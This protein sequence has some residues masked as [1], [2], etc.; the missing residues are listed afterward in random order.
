MA[1]TDRYGLPIT[2]SSPLAA[3]HFGDGMDRLLSFGAGADESFAAAVQADE[4]LAVAHAGV[5]LLAVA[6]G[7]AATAR[8]AAERARRTVGAAT[9][10]EQRHVEALSA[11]IAGETARGLALV[12]EHVA[13]FPRDALLVNQTSSAIGFAGGSRREEQRLTFLERLAP[14]YGDDWWFQSAL[15]FTYH[16]VDR[17]EEARRLSERSLAQYPGNAN[18]SHNIA[19]VYFEAAD[20]DA[21]A[22]FMEDW[23]VGYDPRA[24][25]HCHLAWHLAMF[26]LHRGRYARAREVFE[27]DILGAVNPRLAMIDGSALLWRFRLDGEPDEP[28]AWR[29]LADLAER[30]SR[31]GFVFGEMHAAVAYASCGDETALAKL[32]DGLRALDAK[33][34]P[35]AGAVALPL[36]LGIAAYT[37]DDHAGALAHLEPVEGEIHRIGGSHAQWELFEETMVDCYLRLER[38]DDATRLVRRRLERRASPRDLRWLDRANR[39]S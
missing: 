36:V 20:N 4:G 30:V 32:I 29:R 22:A 9:R 24:S 1:I 28:Q 5:A 15:A 27:R 17:F 38:Y 25:F 31:P 34:H 11:L 23:L 35:I 6:Q 14:A 3:R 16:E 2:T 33:G 39:A 7:D 18:A 8:A 26:E 21:G 19:H 12:D 10:R 13:E 37:A